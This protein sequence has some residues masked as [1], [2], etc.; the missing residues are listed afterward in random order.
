MPVIG[1]SGREDWKQVIEGLSKVPM[2]FDN[3][4]PLRDALA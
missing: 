3:N 1:H 2:F 4:K